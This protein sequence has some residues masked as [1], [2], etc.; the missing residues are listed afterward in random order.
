MNWRAITRVLLPILA[1]LVIAYD[2]V[3]YLRGGVQ[4]TIS[5]V[6]LGWSAAAPL[7]PF[8]V[9]VLC[10]HLFWPQPLPSDPP[11]RT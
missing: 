10:G 9:G 5:R 3:A 2:V 7:L 6:V 4:A 11:N 8:G 1:L